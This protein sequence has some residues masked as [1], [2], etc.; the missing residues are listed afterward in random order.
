MYGKLF[1]D[2][3]E[4]PSRKFDDGFETNSWAPLR[5]PVE[6]VGPDHLPFINLEPFLDTSN[7]DEFHDE[8]N[9]ALSLIEDYTFPNVNGTIPEELQEFE[10]QTHPSN[11]LH[12]IE[13]HDPTGKHLAIINSLPQKQQKLKYA[14]YA[15]GAA[16]AWHFSVFLLQ[17]EYLTKSDVSKRTMGKNGHHFPNVLSYVE[18]VLPFKHVSRAILFSTFQGSEM[19]CHRDWIRTESNTAHH[20]CFN[21]GPGRRAF[22]YDCDAEKKIHV[23]EG[24]RAYLFNDQDYHGVSAIPYFAYTIRVDGE[25]TDEFCEK[26]GFVD[27]KISGY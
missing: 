7:Y 12:Y 16:Q 15:L 6:G 11:I 27:R 14:T 5:L 21:F 26:L 20:I 10:G 13:Q 3:E 18:N 22:V 17:N 8:V 24:C 23:E 1:V 2:N 4:W 9:I 19:I 25:F